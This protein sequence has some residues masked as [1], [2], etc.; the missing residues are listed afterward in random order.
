[1]NRHLTRSR[2]LAVAAL[3]FAGGVVFAS[4]MDWTRLVGAQARSGGKPAVT[5]AQPLAEAQGGFVAVAERVTPAVVAIDAQRDGRRVTPQPRQQQ[6]PQLPPGFEQFFQFD[7]P[8]SRDQEQTGSGFIVTRDGYV[9]TNNHVI[10]GAD[11]EIGRAH[12]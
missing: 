4:S 7:D 9:L 6:R 12:V 8:Q 10:E 5:E 1:M 3:A 2:I 11:R